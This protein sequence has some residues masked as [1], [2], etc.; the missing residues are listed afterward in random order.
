MRDQIQNVNPVSRRSFVRAGGVAG[1]LTGLGLL[2]Q[3]VAAEAGGPAG[4]ASRPAGEISSPA[5][6]PFAV[7]GVVPGLTAHADL[8]ARRSESGIGALAPWADRLWFVTYLAHTKS[9]G[10][11]TGLYSVDDRMTLTKHAEGVPGT[12]ANRMV[13][14]PSLQL[15]IGP[16]VIDPA[17]RVRTFTSLVDHRLTATM[18]HLT[19]PAN[20]V[21]FLTME[22]LLFEADVHTLQA[23]Q[24]FDVKKELNMP[25]GA[26][27]HFKGG[28]TGAGRVVVSNNT[29]DEPDHLG[30]PTGGRLG[31][32]DG[33]AWTTLAETA[34]CEVTGRPSP[35]HAH[36]L[37]TG[38]DRSSVIL[39]VLAAG[40]WQTYRLPAGSH[41]H[42]HMWYTEWPR[43]REVE[44]ERLL[45]DMHGLFYELSPLAYGGRVWGVKPICQ[46][47]RMVPDFCTWR[48]MLVL[49]G[50]Q[51][52]A[53]GGNLEA[54]EPQS[55]LWFGK[56]DDLWSFG[57]PQGWGGPWRETKVEAGVP[58]DPFLMTGFDKKCLHLTSDTAGQIRVEV[59]FLGDGTW[60]TYSALQVPAGGYIHHEFPTGF[61]AHWVRLVARE[62]CTATA[63]FVY[64]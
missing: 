39:K 63:Q 35:A 3:A 13:H 30:R 44:T 29:Y 25:A 8:A 14:A 10:S 58:S 45:M 2:P 4:P 48:G 40:K 32:W 15:V 24:L 41:C 37:A 47:L 34:F 22:G 12:Y 20:Q 5:P 6:A 42:D 31:E 54:G 26:Y 53:V 17:G 57:K 46:H 16:H 59:D 28:F 9:T 62:A 1:G 60:H 18:A 19:D 27:S 50:D 11:G 7:S 49:A 52:T 36:V 51:V 38:W 55:N 61:S 23:R 33:K 21:Y 56:T 64:T 43:I